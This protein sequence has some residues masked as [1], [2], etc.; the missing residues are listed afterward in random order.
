MMVALMAV[1]MLVL[2]REMYPNNRLNL[3]LGLAS[4]VIFAGSF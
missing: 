4:L 2:M 3:A 1:L